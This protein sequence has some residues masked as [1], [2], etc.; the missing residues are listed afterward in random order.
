MSTENR[1]EEIF[2]NTI[3]LLH[4]K[5]VQ[6]KK[7]YNNKGHFSRVTNHLF[8][9]PQKRDKI[10]RN[11]ETFIY[12]NDN[13]Y[14]NGHF[15]KLGV[16]QTLKNLIMYYNDVLNLDQPIIDCDKK[17]N[18]YLTILLGFCVKRTYNPNLPRLFPLNQAMRIS[19]KNQINK[20]HEIFKKKLGTKGGSKKSKK[21]SSVKRS[22]KRTKVTIGIDGRKYYFRGGKRVKAPKKKR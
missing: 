10:I 5:L 2:T 19:G 15:S 17:I 4:E 16:C 22:Q 9:N 12:D 8:D 21:K 14:I 1:F 6:V 18:N 7:Y 11:L 20:M 3:E 13:F